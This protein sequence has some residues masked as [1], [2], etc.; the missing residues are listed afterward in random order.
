MDVQILLD[1]S[2]FAD[3]ASHWMGLDAFS[4][5]VIGVH[6]DAVLNGSRPRGA[7]DIWVVVLDQGHVI[8]VAMHTPPFPVFLPRLPEGVPTAIAVALHRRGHD[9]RG[10]NGEKRS[11]TE[12]A[13]VWA[14]RSGMAAELRRA[15]RMYRLGTLRP[16]PDTSGEPHHAGPGERDLVAEWFVA[17]HAETEA[18][19][20]TDARAMADRRLAT[21]DLWLWID[22]GNPVSLAATHRPAAGVARIGPVYTPPGR[23]QQGYGSAVT[24]RATQAALDAGATHVVLY[25]DLANPTSNAIY[26]RIGYLPDHDAEER[27]FKLLP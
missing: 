8:G 23:R 17:F 10:V 14:E 22:E 11:A 20:G 13:G 7:E 21:G 26:Q 6:L 1:P 3:C 2:T 25:T 27:R 9:V 4:T 18:D 19:E 16:P 15:T 5:N 24:A 12:F